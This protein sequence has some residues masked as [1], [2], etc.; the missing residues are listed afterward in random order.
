MY[1]IQTANSAGTAEVLSHPLAFL[2][3][4]WSYSQST[5]T[6]SVSPIEK[7]QHGDEIE[8]LLPQ[9]GKESEKGGHSSPKG[10]CFWQ[11]LDRKNWDLELCIMPWGVKRKLTGCPCDCCC[12]LGHICH[13]KLFCGPTTCWC[14]ER[15]EFVW[16]VMELTVM[17]RA[18]NLQARGWRDA[19][20]SK[21]CTYY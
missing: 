11:R 14:A 4:F 3:L 6:S 5:H 13:V 18:V 8:Q 17:F 16:D 15:K 1:V 21:L 20:L 9:K 7:K 12:P 19:R 2:S 10:G